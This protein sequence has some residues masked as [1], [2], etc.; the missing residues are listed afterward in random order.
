MTRFS[1][2]TNCLCRFLSVNQA[3]IQ[4]YHQSCLSLPV[5]KSGHDPTIPPTACVSPRIMLGL[6]LPTWFLSM[7]ISNTATVS[8]MIPIVEAVLAEIK[9]AREGLPRDESSDTGTSY[10]VN[11]MESFTLSIL[12]TEVP[13]TLLTLWRPSLYLFYRHRYQWHC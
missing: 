7:W 12:Q 1:Y 5:C 6:M 13:V 8:M 11:S 4:L 9:L 10:T 2:T 3:M